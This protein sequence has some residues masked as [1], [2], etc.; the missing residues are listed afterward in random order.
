[1]PGRQEHTSRNVGLLVT[2]VMFGLTA[3]AVLA[4]MTVVLGRRRL[5]PGRLRLAT[6]PEILGGG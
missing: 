6:Q 3:A 5:R 1:M 4:G 2:A